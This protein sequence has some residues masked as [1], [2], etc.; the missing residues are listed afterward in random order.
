MIG[1]RAAA[2]LES[3]Y[4]DRN[5]ASLQICLGKLCHK[6]KNFYL[7]AL[8]FFSVSCVKARRPVCQKLKFGFN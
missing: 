3:C 4:T 6:R 1:F 7:D 5:A 2:V 8:G